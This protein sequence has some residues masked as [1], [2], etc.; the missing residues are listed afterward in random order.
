MQKQSI[1]KIKPRARRLS[2]LLLIQ[3][4]LF[5]AGC[6]EGEVITSPDAGEVVSISASAQE[7]LRPLAVGFSIS[8]VE[9]LSNAFIHFG[10]GDS[11]DVSS[12]QDIFTHT[13]TD[14]GTFTATLTGQTSSGGFFTDSVDISVL[15]DVNLIVS[16]FAI[17]R[18]INVTDPINIET[19]SAIIQNIGSDA[20][21]GPG[22]IEVGYFLS[23]DDVITVDDILIGDTTIEIGDS[24]T[25]SQVPFGFE[26]LGPGDNYQFNVQ[27]L[28]KRNIPTG[29]Y[30]AG[31]IVDYIDYYDW[32][33]FPRATDTLEYLFPLESRLSDKVYF[34][35]SNEND[36]SRTLGAY[37]VTVNNALCKSDQYED[38]DTS[39]QATPLTVGS[40]QAHNFCL[41]NSDW[42]KFE[43]V[44]GNVYKISTDSLGLETDTQLILYDRDGLSILIFDDNIGGAN[45]GGD[46]NRFD[47]DN[48]A[49]GGT[50]L[51]DETYDLSIGWPTIP[52]S[53]IV[54]EAEFSGTYFV[55]IRTTTC[56]QNQDY[57]C[58]G[59]PSQGIEDSP[60]GVGLNTEYTISLQ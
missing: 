32:Y 23:T 40:S 27:L 24:F 60:D 42:V 4:S 30:Y 14:V 46:G 33:N 31:A 21:V 9:Q 3:I 8:S 19:V 15:G 12:S 18:T 48:P 1:I 52:K 53:E 38:D 37:Q 59:D 58:D 6:S 43:A 13:Y 36:N 41:D 11:L 28:I 47:F 39:D 17:D 56:D 5:L 26:R 51:E 34:T 55:K 25:Q 50:F 54:W 57:Y 7:G 22:A 10:D 49:P 45:S 16:S 2:A 20:L 29:T 35:E 44:A